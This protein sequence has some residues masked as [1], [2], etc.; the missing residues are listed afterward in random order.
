M[1]WKEIKPMDQKI[2]MIADWQSN[3]FTKTDLSKKYS[4]S[5]K[6]VNKW[7]KR[8]AIIGIDGL[9]DR[10]RAPKRSPHATPMHI[11]N[12]IV[13]HKLENR[14]RGP[15]KVH[16]QLVKTYPHIEWPS[17]ST[18]GYWLKK[19]GLV[20]T[21][22]RRKNVAPYSDPFVTIED[23]NDVWSADY[24]GDFK[25]QDGRKCYP[26]T[27]SDNYS[28]FL[29]KCYGLLGPRYQETRKV[30]ELA[31]QEFGLPYAIRTDN[32]QPFASTSIAGLSRLSIWWIQLGI[33][34]E[35]IDKGCPQQNGR[36]ERMHRTLKYELLDT[37]AKTIK[38]QQKQFD[39]FKYDYNYIRPHE[40]LEQKTPN[41]Y[42]LRSK[43]PYVSKLQKPSYG[44]DFEVRQVRNNGEIQF[45]GNYYFMTNL[46]DDQP[47]G[48]KQTTNDTWDIY[49]S[50]YRIAS[51]DERN[52]QI[53]NS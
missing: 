49:Y 10:N 48:L 32:G 30:F 39:Y 11:V 52:K 29:L 40:S 15:K 9:K 14:K 35:R 51:L 8:Y 21:R 53:I 36:H 24:K 34:P 22:K 45:K 20:K 2:Q 37:T 19:H 5:R 26:L 1:P 13:K 47:V 50:F 44:Y 33:I 42:Y 28:R 43:R 17:A 3:Q 12:R 27:I 16:A 6:T 4:I 25:T 7:I 38:E 18:V 31:F 23:P 46:L 41:E